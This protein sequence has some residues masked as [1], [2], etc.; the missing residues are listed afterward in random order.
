MAKRIPDAAGLAAL[1]D[2]RV[3]ATDR[4]V[5]ATAVR[6]TLAHLE[7]KAPG[8]SVEVR[9]PPFGAVQILEGTS[10]RRGTPP[11]V[12]EMDEDTWLHLATGS[13]TWADAVASARVNA[14]GERAD[15]GPLLPLSHATAT[16]AEDA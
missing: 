3:G 9:V 2:W 14:S 13:L 7:A 4:T 15:L 6:Y 10:H 5:L 8:R 1:A 11:A 16:D 12:I